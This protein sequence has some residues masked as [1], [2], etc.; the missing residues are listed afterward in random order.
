MFLTE[1]KHKNLQKKH[2]TRQSNENSWQKQA[3][4]IPRPVMQ[5]VIDFSSPIYGQM[6]AEQ[7]VSQLVEGNVRLFGEEKRELI[8]RIV[9]DMDNELEHY[10]VEQVSRE[11]ARQARVNLP[12]HNAK[13]QQSAYNQLS[14]T[15]VTRAC[16]SSGCLDEVIECRN[17]KN[18]HAERLILRQLLQHGETR[19]QKFVLT[20]NNSPCILCAKALAEWVRKTENKL[21]IRFCNF[22]G[23]KEKFVQAAEI[24]RSE[25]I[26]LHT[27]SLSNQHPE[28]ITKKYAPRMGSLDRRQ[29]A[30]REE[31]QFVSD[32]ESEMYEEPE[33][34]Y[35][36]G[37]AR[38]L[39]RLEQLLWEEE[40]GSGDIYAEGGFRYTPNHPSVRSGG[41]CFW[42]SLRRY[43]FTDQEL[44][45]AA[46]MAGLEVDRH[47]GYTDAF[48]VVENLSRIRNAFFALQIVEFYYGNPNAQGVRLEGQGYV[49][50]LAYFHL[51]SEGDGHFVPPEY[52]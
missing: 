43:Y 11:V 48:R 21:T 40:Y 10:T 1:Q 38:G 7:R 42:D 39:P 2:C 23:K 4:R 50:R 17:T 29:E 44:N 33:Q 22:Y 12:I 34:T 27:Y 24:L 47:V 3:G 41:E 9:T 26:K 45:Q 6:T 32:S 19:G 52:M 36:A 18:G 49:L 14:F 25:G 8:W 46:A 51:P 37:S 5:R 31:A 35:S 15:S 30:L 16:M 20:I 13:N 28:Q